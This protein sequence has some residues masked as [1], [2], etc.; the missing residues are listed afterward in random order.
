MRV[1][2]KAYLKSFSGCAAVRRGFRYWVDSAY[3]NRF[4]NLTTLFRATPN[5]HSI[6]SINPSSTTK[7]YTKY[8]FF[9]S[10]ISNIAMSVLNHSS[11]SLQ[12]QSF[13][14]CRHAIF[15]C[16]SLWSSQLLELDILD[17][18]SQ[19]WRLSETADTVYAMTMLP[20]AQMLV[21]I[22][23]N[24]RSLCLCLFLRLFPCA[25]STMRTS[26]LISLRAARHKNRSSSAN[27]ARQT[28]SGTAIKQGLSSPS[29]LFSPLLTTHIVLLGLLGA[30]QIETKSCSLLRLKIRFSQGISHQHQPTA[31]CLLL[32]TV[33]LNVQAESSNC[34][35]VLG[36]V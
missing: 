31:G 34:G 3:L 6:T 15:T 17:A 10:R 2:V 22:Q 20:H 27:H 23:P 29:I 35:R 36:Y 7:A 28:C 9:E 16:F 18:R 19:H 21:R 13:D 25:T 5:S 24:A 12:C 14:A 11:S 32:E 26:P 30:W 1:A 4:L 33:R 8:P